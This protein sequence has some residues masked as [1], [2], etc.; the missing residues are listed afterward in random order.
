M[1][2]RIDKAIIRLLLNYKDNYL[3]TYQIAKKIGI[4][5]LTAKRHLVN[6][7]KEGYV[8]MTTGGRWREYE[9]EE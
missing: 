2:D 3:T 8:D 7:K 9:V 4:A 1:L 6:L 5:P